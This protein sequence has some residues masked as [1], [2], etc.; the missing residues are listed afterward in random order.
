VLFAR[1]LTGI[2]AGTAP[3]FLT[4]FVTSRG[5]FLFLAQVRAAAVVVST[6][7]TPRSSSARPCQVTQAEG[8]RGDTSERPNHTTEP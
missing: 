2:R 3:V 7:P 1:V 8:G 4:S 6:R 5:L